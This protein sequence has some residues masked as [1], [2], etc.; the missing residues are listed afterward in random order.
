M[1]YIL[2]LVLIG[3]RC[4]HHRNSLANRHC[5]RFINDFRGVASRPNVELVSRQEKTSDSRRTG[6]AA[7]E[8]TNVTPTPAM[9]VWTASSGIE[10]GVELLLSYGKGF[11][12]HRTHPS[13]S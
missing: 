5:T 3:C 2:D 1:A 7:R 10:A 8:E 9:E 12:T 13:T 11:W 4:C 6:K